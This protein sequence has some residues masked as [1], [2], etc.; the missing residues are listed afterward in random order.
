MQLKSVIETVSKDKNLKKEVVARAV[1]TALEKSMKKKFPF[2]RVEA[3]FDDSFDFKVYLFKQVVDSEPEMLDEESEIN[4][5]EA[6]KFDPKCQVGDEIGEEISE[7]EV[8]AQLGRIGASIGKSALNEVIKA[9]EAT[10]GFEQYSKMKGKV[11]TGTVQNSDKKGVLV[12]LGVVEA[13]IPRTDLMPRDKFR[14]NNTVEALLKDI[15]IEKGQLK[16]TLSRTAPN[17]VLQLLKEE[18]PEIDQGVVELV[19]VVREPGVRAK[20]V[21]DTEE[22]LNAAALCIGTRGHKIQKVMERLGGERVDVIQYSDDLPEFLSGLL[23]GVNIRH[24]TES[25]TEIKGEV[26]QEDF[27]KAIGR[28]GINVRLAGKILGR[29]VTIV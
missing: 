11:V 7:E 8:K 29:K 19:A 25:D 9:E 1:A 10:I 26:L 6:R 22:Q 5:P 24:I 3:Q 4:L 18:V 13:Y 17:F 27:A 28:E 23:S 16:I 20:V 14:R 12:N 21:V 15:S 2:G